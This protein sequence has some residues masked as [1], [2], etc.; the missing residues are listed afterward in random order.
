MIF[1]MKLLLKVAAFATLDGYIHYPGF[2]RLFLAQFAFCKT[3]LGLSS[4]KIL[5]QGS[6]RDAN[7]WS[8][9]DTATTLLILRNF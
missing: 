2:N 6:S 1:F 8:F 4:L 3:N 9:F 5:Y 7:Y